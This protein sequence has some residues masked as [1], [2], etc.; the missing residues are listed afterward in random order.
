MP[1]SETSLLNRARA[2]ADAPTESFV[3]LIRIARLDPRRDLRFSNWSGISFDGIDLRGFD[4]TGSRLTGCD[5]A[6]ARIEGA[7]FE[8]ADLKGANLRKA[9][10]WGAYLKGWSPPERQVET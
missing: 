5:F 1:P 10:D 3:E 7:R 2:V 9:R 4:F 6:N 8:M